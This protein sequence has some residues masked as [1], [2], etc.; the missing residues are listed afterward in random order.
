VV[1]ADLHVLVAA[2]GDPVAVGKLSDYQQGLEQIALGGSTSASG[3]LAKIYD[4]G[5]GVPQDA[6]TALAWIRWGKACTPDADESAGKD[7]ERLEFEHIIIDTAEVELRAEA[8]LA[9]MQ[10]SREAISPS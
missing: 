3:S 1:A 6:A 5:L 10:R 7:L 2:A 4:R 9:E 8:L